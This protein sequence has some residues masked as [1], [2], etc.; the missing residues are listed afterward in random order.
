MYMYV[1]ILSEKEGKKLLLLEK[2]GN[3]L[4]TSPVMHQFELITNVIILQKALMV[5]WSL[6][7]FFFFL[8]ERETGYFAGDK[9]LQKIYVSQDACFPNN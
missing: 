7:I 3:S 4:C 1:Y 9:L 6:W 2:V 8:K 5:S